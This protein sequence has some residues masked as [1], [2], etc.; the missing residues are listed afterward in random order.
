MHHD[1]ELIKE[2]RDQLK[3]IFEK[4]GHGV[5]LYLDDVHKTCNKK[6]AEILGYKTAAEWEKLDYLFLRKF[7]DDK[8][9]KDL[10]HAYKKAVHK[11]EASKLNVTWNTKTNKKV[12]TEV[13]MVPLEFKGH[14][15]ALHFV[16]KVKEKNTSISTA[17]QH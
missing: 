14:I 16:E 2:F 13:V 5:Y 6:F 9:Q 1:A 15:L 17:F 12:K 3:Q 10:V 4:S 11:F 8:S 7:V